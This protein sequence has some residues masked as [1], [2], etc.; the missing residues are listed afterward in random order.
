M[1]MTFTTIQHKGFTL[2]EMV[3]SLGIFALVAVIAIG[4]LLKI[5]DANKKAHSLQTTINDLNFALDAMTRELR[6]GSGYFCSSGK[7]VDMSN[8]QVNSRVPNSCSL[9]T[10]ATA[11]SG[12]GAGFN[13]WTIIFT[14]SKVNAGSPA[15]S[16]RYAYYFDGSQ[17]WKAEQVTVNDATFTYYPVISNNSNKVETVINFTAALSTIEVE[18]GSSAAQP[19]VRFH[20]VGTAGAK[21]RTKTAFDIQTM[22]SQ[23]L[24]D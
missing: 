5:V 17:L 20:F 2:V 6:V 11:G 9:I 12:L 1:Y 8:S 7:V 24:P 13:G 4:A 14:S 3:V 15:W 22:I 10:G 19:L 21:E 18:T 16:P 23:R